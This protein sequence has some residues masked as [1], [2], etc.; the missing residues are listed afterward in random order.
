[1]TLS[2]LRGLVAAV[3]P[4]GFV[5]LKTFSIMSGEVDVGT[6]VKLEGSA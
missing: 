4:C 5:H 3:N 6:M 1:M 2:F